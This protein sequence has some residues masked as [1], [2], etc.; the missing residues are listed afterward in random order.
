MSA[1]TLRSCAPRLPIFISCRS[2]SALWVGSTRQPFQRLPCLICGM[3]QRKQKLK[4]LSASRFPATS[5][6][7]RRAWCLEAIGE[8][9]LNRLMRTRER[10]GPI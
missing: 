5:T 4:D 10:S 1:P 9:A 8:R 6:F 3:G 7:Q 2:T